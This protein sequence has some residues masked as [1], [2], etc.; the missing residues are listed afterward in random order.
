MEFT[1]RNWASWESD[2]PAWFT[3]LLKTTVPDEYI[4]KEFLASLGGANRMRRGSAIGSVRES[5][6]MIEQE[7]AAVVEE[8]KVTA[9]G[10]V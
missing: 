2:K 8:D 9:D 6:R 1:L 3:P 7:E 4:P 10:G 5:F